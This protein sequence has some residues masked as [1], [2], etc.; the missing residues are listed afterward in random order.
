MEFGFQLGRLLGVVPTVRDHTS[1]PL[2]LGGLSARNSSPHVGTHLLWHM[3]GR[4]GRPSQRLLGGTHTLLPKRLAVDLGCGLIGASVSDHRLADNKGR[5]VCLFLSAAEC[6]VDGG[7]IVAV[8][9]SE[10]VPIVRLESVGHI[11]AE[12]QVG[13]PFDLNVV[14]VV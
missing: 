6:G 9:R 5:P 10:D 1:S 7:D 4:S 8:H 3:E 13:G 14:V 2:R 12:G 11:L